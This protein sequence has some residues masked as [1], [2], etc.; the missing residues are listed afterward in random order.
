MMQKSDNFSSLNCYSLY[1]LLYISLTNTKYPRSVA[2]LLPDPTFHGATPS[3]HLT[4]IVQ[5]LTMTTPSP[6]S[7]KHPLTPVL[8]VDSSRSDYNSKIK[9]AG[10]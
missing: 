6:T 9:Y 4:R 5:L 3:F 2:H 7:T 1:Q 10:H 8:S